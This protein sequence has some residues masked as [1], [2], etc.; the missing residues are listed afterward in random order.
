[1]NIS[2]TLKLRFNYIW[3]F[4]INPVFSGYSLTGASVYLHA[5]I[6]LKDWRT[7]PCTV[8]TTLIM[9]QRMPSLIKM[10]FW[11][12]AAALISSCRPSTS[13]FILA[14]RAGLS[15]RENTG[16]WQAVRESAVRIIKAT[17]KEGT[18]SQNQ[19]S[20]ASESEQSKTTNFK[21]FNN[22]PTQR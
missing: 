4:W 12:A 13:P 14:W 7:F 21:H 10:A 2:F 3:K 18:G 5:Q 15:A 6:R 17:C 16:A 20:Q 19:A 11:T 8:T 22:L 1:M 9:K